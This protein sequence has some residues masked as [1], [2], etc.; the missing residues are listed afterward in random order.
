M[1]FVSISFFFV[2]LLGE[3]RQR[4]LGGRTRA[5]RELGSRTADGRHVDG[6]WCRLVV[7]FWL[8]VVGLVSAVG[9]MQ[10]DL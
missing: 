3:R 10:I 8:L 1:S 6:R 4:A 9:S 2:Q 7:V 5:G